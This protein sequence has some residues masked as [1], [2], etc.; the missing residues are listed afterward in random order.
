MREDAPSVHP[1][2]PHFVRSLARSAPLPGCGLPSVEKKKKH[3]HVTTKCTLRLVPRLRDP[4]GGAGTHAM[5]KTM[6]HPQTPL[7][8]GCSCNFDINQSQN[9][10]KSAVISGQISIRG[11]ASMCADMCTYECVPESVTIPYQPIESGQKR[12]DIL[13][14]NRSWPKMCLHHSYNHISHAMMDVD[15]M[16][17]DK[18]MIIAADHM[19]VWLMMV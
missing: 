5:T 12:T 15:M 19:H 16:A 14:N 8:T 7:P 1:F 9:R 17:H 3:H 18:L 13:A 6:T 2:K 10:C 11:G 4:K